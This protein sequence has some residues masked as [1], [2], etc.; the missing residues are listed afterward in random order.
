V[1]DLEEKEQLDAMR[2]WWKENGNYVIGGVLAGVIMIFGWNRWQTGI[3][4]AEVA[5]S[6]LYEDILY[7]ADLGLLD[8]AIAPAE[9]LLENY[10]SSPYAAQARLAMAR[11]YMD[12]SRD[13]DAAD[14]LQGLV[15]SSPEKE[16]ALLGRL[17][18]AK[19]LLYQ[20]K[21]EEAL[22]LVSDRPESGF[23][24]RYSELM[25][26]AYVS[27]GEFDKAEAAYIAA[28]NDNPAAPTI[29]S[30]FV[31]LK[32]NDLPI[33]SEIASAAAA[34]GIAPESESDVATEIGEQGEAEPA[35]EPAETD[36]DSEA[37]PA[38]ETAETDPDSEAQ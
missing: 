37:E 23:A 1:E 12:S 6:T 14:M 15:D 16:V 2:D 22:E 17:R 11:M 24:A 7:A 26:D 18:L 35:S 5:A 25:G 10:G 4:D 32:I 20:G 36:P 34:A 3:A 9:E 38:S 27:M 29:D 33:A 28:L 30:N 8:N 31:Q 13:Q 21:A 19:I